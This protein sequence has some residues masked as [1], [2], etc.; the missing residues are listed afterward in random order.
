L[1]PRFFSHLDRHFGEFIA[2]RSAGSSGEV[3]LAAALVSRAAANG[4]VCLDL[5]EWAGRRLPDDAGAGPGRETPSLDLWV[6]RLRAAPAV[7]RP[8]ERRPL[9]LDDRRR[10]YLCRY[11]EYEQGVASGILERSAGPLAAGGIEPIRRAMARVFPDEGTA[12]GHPQRLAA[13]VAALSRFAVITGGPGTGKTFAIAGVMALI[14]ATHPQGAAR[15]WLAAP[16]GKAAA[17]LKDSLKAARPAAAGVDR[18]G[19]RHVPAAEEIGTLHR[20]LKPRPGTPYFVHNRL[21][22]VPADAVIVDE[23]SMVDLALMAKLMDALRA[24]TRLVLVGDKDQL[25]SVQAGAV[26]GDICGRGRREGLS[27]E[28]AGVLGRVTGAA[29]AAAS[30]SA[31]GL[32]DCIVELRRSYRFA[33]GSPIGELGRAVNAGDFERT[34]DILKDPGSGAVRWLESEDP[35]RI[36]R[37]LE[38]ALLDGYAACFRAA[39]AEEAL[40]GH[41]GFKILCGHNSGERGTQALNR[42][43]EEI[44]LR[45]G[46]IRAGDRRHFPWYSGR[47]VLVTRNAYGLEL[48]NGDLGVCRTDPGTAAG[49][50]AVWF[51]GAAGGL[52]SLAPYRLPEHETAYAMTVHRSQG[53]EYDHVLLVLPKRD[54]PVLT[55]E[56]VYTAVTRARRSVSV[57]AGRAVLQAAVG[58]RIERVSGLRDALW[59]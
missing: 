26:L 24:E 40:K 37:A 45:E 15:I 49:R 22:P 4:D 44:F 13:A 52:R 58:R 35:A 56:L 23:A 12:A 25:A 50:P 17:R 31:P 51:E 9:I 39:T 2:G 27:R 20:L 48:Y 19:V 18:Q 41:A 57:I 16:T 53:S 6:E 46:L 14:S 43:A 28:A 8:G 10:L 59:P 21:N 1:A 55:R 42:L 7:G 30:P 29:L 11:W 3:A 36:R 47:P 32:A 54:S 33:P 34:A 38:E 5:Q